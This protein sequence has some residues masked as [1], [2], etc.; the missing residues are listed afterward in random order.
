MAREQFNTRLDDDR[1]ARVHEY[2]N[3]HGLGKADALRELL[4][5]GLD[6]NQ[7]ATEPPDNSSTEANDTEQTQPTDTKTRPL[8]N[9][10]IVL[11]AVWGLVV[12][13]VAFLAYT[14]RIP[15]L[16]IARGLPVLAFPFS[17]LSAVTQ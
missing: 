16:V 13:F 5:D 2:M 12:C 3:E 11:L 9:P 10:F 6:A 7:P 8:A 4:A 17:P 14:G 15:D 1:A